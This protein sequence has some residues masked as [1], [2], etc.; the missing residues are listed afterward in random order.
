VRTFLILSLTLLIACFS[1]FTARTGFNSDFPVFYA[2]GKTILEPQTPA[3][4]VYDVG[5]LSSY[6]VPEASEGEKKFIY[7]VAAAYL[8]APL[9]LLPY[10]AAKATMI[11]VNVVLY[12]AAIALILKF[13][14]V[15]AR[16]V[17]YTLLLAWLWFPFVQGIREGQVNAIIL[18][19][20]IL[21]AYTATKQRSMLSGLLLA[22]AALFKLFPLVIALA[23]GVKDRRIPA[24][25]TLF[26]VAS[27]LIPGS[28]KWFAAI[29][30]IYK[31]DSMLTYLL[32]NGSPLAWMSLLYAA[33]I[34]GYSALI[35]YRFRCVDNLTLVAFLIPAVLLLMPVL[36]YD[37]MTLLIAS[38]VCL[39]M[40]AARE[41]RLLL[42][43]AVS[44]FALIDASLF[45]SRRS[46]IL[47]LPL[48]SKVLMTLGLLIC[49][50]AMV[51]KMRG[52]GQRAAG[53]G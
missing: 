51:W 44:S 41:N 25:C 24:Y 15:A 13:H 30:N 34:A 48:A 35:A 33:G 36:E 14:S 46:H 37:H 8:L 20:I 3:S 23:L 5:K 32:F 38:Y 2:A 39:T 43:S 27:F 18:F 21:A 53:V 31:A 26:F 49:W 1:L 12:L 29:G 50:A 42:V 16:R 47:V 19:L 11:F 7:S 17:T 52:Y 10:F 9:A 4:S 22:V 6:T 28:L 45:I 40:P